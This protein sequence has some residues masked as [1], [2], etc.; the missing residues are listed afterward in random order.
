MDCSQRYDLAL[1]RFF[2]ANPRLAAEADDVSEAEANAIG[3]SLKDLQGKRRAQIFDRAARNLEIDSFELAIRLVAESP[4][5]AQTW[6]LKQL[7]KHADAI[8]VDWE[9]FKQLNDIEE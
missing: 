1:V 7:R 9:E 8:G 2:A 4:E 5:Q 6:R 3:V